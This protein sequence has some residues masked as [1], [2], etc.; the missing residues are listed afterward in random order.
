MEILMNQLKSKLA[1]K[2]MDFVEKMGK[3][4]FIFSIVVFAAVVIK[5]F[6]FYHLVKVTSNFILVLIISC[7]ITYLILGS[8]KNKW[9]SVSLYFLVSIVMFCDVTYFSFFNRYLSLSMLGAAEVLGDIGESIKQV[10]RPANFVMFMDVA[11][12][13]LGLLLYKFAPEYIGFKNI[14]NNVVDNGIMANIKR[15]YFKPLAAVIIITLIITNF[16]QSNLLTSASNQEIYSFRVKDILTNT[17]GLGKSSNLVFA[18]SYS[19]NMSGPLFGVAEGK[20]L[21]VI[22][23]ESLQN[24]VVGLEYNGQEVTPNLNKLILGNSIYFDNYYQQI[25]SGN[26]SDAEFATN[27]SMLGVLKS[28]TYKTFKD[29]YFRGLPKLLKEKGYETAVFHAYEFRGF[30]SREEI[31]PNMGFD[32]FY[33]GII[34]DTQNRPN[35][36]YM[37]TEWMGW[38]LTDT[39]FFKQAIPM[40]EKLNEPFYS[41]VITLSNHHP[42]EMLDKYQFIKL[43]PEDKGTLAGNYINSAAYTDYALGQF[44]DGLKKDGIYDN[45]IIAIYGDHAGLVNNEETDEVMGRILGKK[46]DFDEVMHIPLIINMSESAADINQKISTAGGQLDFLPTIAYLMGFE[47]LD[48]VYQGQNLITAE[49]GFVAEHTFMVKGSFFADKIAFEMSRD[50]IFENARAWNLKT[51]EPVSLDGLYN[52]YLQSVKIS[53]SSQFFIDNN[54]LHKIYVEGQTVNQA[55]K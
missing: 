15:N 40:I 10:L 48:T 24:F 14:N 21:I 42:Y 32:N 4:N 38:G 43:L 39:E 29:N 12:M 46:Y 41:F 16:P 33:G 31:Y 2:I 36:S 37:M 17:I 6:E 18:N 23:V 52:K 8:F 9:I 20:N 13:Y 19:D 45:S 11:I 5:F 1:N 28:Y 47:K 50:G 55:L 53:E 26:T 35:G 22:Q 3:I 51:G 49:K 25:G 7:V 27:N 54:I 44:I 34:N 30:W